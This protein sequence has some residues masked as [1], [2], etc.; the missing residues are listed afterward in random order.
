M[1]ESKFR[2][3]LA[4]AHPKV[5]DRARD[6][7][8]RAERDGVTVKEVRPV[9]SGAADSLAIVCATTL[10]VEAALILIYPPMATRPKGRIRQSL[11]FVGY[12]GTRNV[13]FG[14]RKMTEHLF[15]YYFTEVWGTTNR[16]TRTKRLQALRPDLVNA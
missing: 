2:A 8:E 13:K 15:G 4:S 1:I 9:N 5:A 16:N 3:A 14:A 6:W 7:L 11:L 10:S 12:Y